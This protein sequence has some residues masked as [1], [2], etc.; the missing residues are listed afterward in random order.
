MKVEKVAEVS[1]DFQHS[2][3]AYANLIFPWPGDA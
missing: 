2:G 3:A 1:G